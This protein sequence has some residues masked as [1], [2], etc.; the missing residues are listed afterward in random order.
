MRIVM[1]T[2]LEGS[3]GIFHREMQIASPTPQEYA[4][5][6]RLATREVVAAIEGAWAAGATEILI[7]ALHDIDLE[8]LPA[9]VQVIRGVNF[10]DVTYYQ[11]ERFDALVIVGQHGGAHLVDCALAHTFLPSWQ[12]E[13]GGVLQE[14]WLK[15]IAP[16]VANAPQGEFSTV[17]K[18]WL[19]D[20]LVGESSF[21]ATLAAAYGVPTACVCGCVHACQEVQEM[22]PEV[23]TV[24]VKW[25]INF[26]AARMLSPAGAQEA[27]RQGVAEALKR[28][29][30]IPACPAALGP[31]EVK[32]RYV[33]PERT[34]RTARWPGTRR[35]DEHTVA[36]T[37]PDG[38]HL[39]GLGFMF[40]RPRSAED[41]PTG[42]E[43]N[44]L[45]AF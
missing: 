35:L 25:G 22:V 16:Q 7:D 17:E 11:R 12:I 18:V 45:P 20:R 42:P 10:W 41:G 39:T 32:V 8:M 6:L 36:A 1:S 33:H 5:T 4:R 3:A 13:A 23:G 37:A 31:Q 28:L 24:P 29:A 14:G 19:N 40:A 38:R 9:G 34:D 2:D 30:A 44:A 26:R 21:L 27:I 15:Q 43:R